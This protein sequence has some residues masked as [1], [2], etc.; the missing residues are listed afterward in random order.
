[1]TRWIASDGGALLDLEDALGMLGV[2]EG[3]EPEEDELVLGRD[4][5]RLQ[6]LGEQREREAGDDRAFDGARARVTT[7]TSQ[8]SPKKELK[9]AA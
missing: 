1:M 6:E 9:F 8:N 5:E 3:A 7:S 4:A 2:G